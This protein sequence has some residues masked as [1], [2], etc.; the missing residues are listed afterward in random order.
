MHRSLLS[1]SLFSSFV[2]HAQNCVLVDNPAPPG[3]WYYYHTGVVRPDGSVITIADPEVG[4]GIYVT[5][6]APDGSVLGNKQIKHM[7]PTFWTWGSSVENASNG[8]LLIGGSLFPDVKY[9]ATYLVEADADAVTQWARIYLLDSTLTQHNHFVSFKQHPAGGYVCVHENSEGVSLSH[10]NTT[11][12][13]V[14]TWRYTSTAGGNLRHLGTFPLANGNTLLVAQIAA[15]VFVIDLSPEGQVL[16]SKNNDMG[17]NYM[18]CIMTENNELILAGMSGLEGLLLRLNAQGDPLWKR[19]FT[20]DTDVSFDILGLTETANNHLVFATNYELIEFGAD[21]SFVGKWRRDPSLSQAWGNMLVPRASGS[22]DS[23]VIARD[24]YDGQ[25]GWTQLMLTSGTSSLECSMIDTTGTSTSLSTVPATT[26]VVYAI[27]DS[28]KTWEMNLGPAID[29]NESDPYC[30]LMPNPARPGF[31][32]RVGV[33]IVNGS[34]STTGPITATLTFPSPVTF[35]S[36]NPAPSTVTAN[37]LTWQF[38]ALGA[39]ANR[40]IRP[41][42][43]TPADPDLIGTP[44]QYTLTFTQDSADADPS[45]NTTVFNTHIVGAYDPNDKEVEPT[46]HYVLG[47]DS[48]LNYTIRFQNTGNAA[49]TNVVLVDSLPLDVDV[50]TFRLEA[51]T[52]SCTYHITG[53]G[54]LTFTFNNIQLPDS[55]TNE[56]ASHGSVRFSIRPITPLTPGQ[57][58]SN[59]ADIFFDFNPPIRTPDATVIVTEE[60]GVVPATA[61]AQL[62]VFPIPVTHTVNAVVPSGFNPVVAWAFGVDGRPIQ[63]FRPNNSVQANTFDVQRLAPGGYVLTLVDRQGHRLSA[64]FVKE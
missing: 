19:S 33:G 2:L 59:R 64:R 44:I 51:F 5:H 35:V 25:Q 4:I 15:Q 54:I 48:I 12:I 53:T 50:S 40:L 61:P 23:L 56:S 45:N 22:S 39:H 9:E 7:D 36:C 13:P 43:H 47:A 20:Y 52:H 60:T 63:L 26:G 18:R 8:N 32:H 62:H 31:D 38:P 10:L 46:D 41:R 57:V 42:F 30:F 49:A 11:G 24:L 3:N 58:I 21:G 34:T 17:T 37:S 1:L 16:W 29:F 28:L 14:W 6:W 27:R 55:N